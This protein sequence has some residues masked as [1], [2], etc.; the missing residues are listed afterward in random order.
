MLDKTESYRCEKCKMTSMARIK[1]DL[2]KLPKV[3]V[4]HLKRFAFPS[5]KKIKG[6]SRYP[7]FINMSE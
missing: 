3:I 7:D 6:K 2:S 1:H 4:F 5:M